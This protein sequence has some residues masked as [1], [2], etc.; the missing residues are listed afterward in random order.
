MAKSSLDSLDLTTQFLAK[1][2]GIDKVLKVLRYSTRLALAAG[3]V[4][5][6]QDLTKRLNK[7]ESSVGSAR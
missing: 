5:W 6:N 7:F 4:D 3:L 1:R 2:E